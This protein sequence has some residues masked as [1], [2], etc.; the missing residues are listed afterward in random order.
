M[1][2]KIDPF[3]RRALAGVKDDGTSRASSFTANV[4]LERLYR[5]HT[6]RVDAA[7]RLSPDEWEELQEQKKPYRLESQERVMTQCLSIALELNTSHHPSLRAMFP[8]LLRWIKAILGYVV[9]LEDLVE[10]RT[11]SLEAAHDATIRANHELGSTIDEL[12]KENDRLQGLIRSHE[13]AFDELDA[14]HDDVCGDLNIALAQ[15]QAALDAV[16]VTMLALQIAAKF[17][18]SLIPLAKQ[19]EDSAR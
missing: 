11:T 14:R 19:L 15:R 10:R 13:D 9:E 3:E 12:R 2:T 5:E 17:E 7:I 6:Q 1:T 16:K 8:W 4:L 18:P